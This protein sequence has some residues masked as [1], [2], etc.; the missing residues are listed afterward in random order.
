MMTNGIRGW[1]A[2]A[3]K[4]LNRKW[5][6]KVFKIINWQLIYKLQEG[7]TTEIFKKVWNETYETYSK[8]NEAFIKLRMMMSM[9]IRI[10]F[11]DLLITQQPVKSGWSKIIKK[12]NT[13]VNT[14]THLHRV[15]TRVTCCLAYRPP[16]VSRVIRGVA[17]Y[18]CPSPTHA[19]S[20]RKERDARRVS[21]FGTLPRN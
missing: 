15:L 20:Q 12:H 13:Y 18:L 1:E 7:C 16:C 19:L 14:R 8:R 11:D 4:K 2:D 17:N 5:A 21:H 3:V 6:G 10:H 9:I